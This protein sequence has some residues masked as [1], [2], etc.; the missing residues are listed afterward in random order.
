MKLQLVAPRQG[1]VWVRRSFQVFGRQPLGFADPQ[2]MELPE[3]GQP[4][5]AWRLLG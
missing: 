4:F 3:G 1:F 2:G 5:G